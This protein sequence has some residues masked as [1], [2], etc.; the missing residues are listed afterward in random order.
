MHILGNTCTCQHLDVRTY[1][2][3]ARESTLQIT[4]RHVRTH[5]WHGRG[6]DYNMTDVMAWNRGWS[7]SLL[8]A[9]HDARDSK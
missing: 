7:L 9:Y 3:S 2:A 1:G 8:C 5:Q 4:A 6:D